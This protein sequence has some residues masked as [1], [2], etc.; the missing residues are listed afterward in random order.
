M[1]PFCV[2][3]FIIVSR[4]TNAGSDVDPNEPSGDT[5]LCDGLRDP[6]ND[7][8]DKGDWERLTDW[9]D[10]KLQRYVLDN[11]PEQYDRVD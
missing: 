1:V 7:L 2:V 11:C 8:L 3:L 6:K 5:E 4:I 9:P 10:W